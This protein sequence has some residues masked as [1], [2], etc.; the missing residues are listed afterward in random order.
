MDKF[1]IQPVG[2]LHCDITSKELAPKNYDISDQLG[3][4]EIY[5]KFH[6]ALEGI[7]K[8]SLIVVLFWLHMAERDI[9]KVHPRGDTTRPKRGVFST[10]SPVR[11]N[12][13]AIS[14]LKVES[15]NDNVLT[16]SGLDILDNTPVID[17]KSKV[18]SK[19]ADE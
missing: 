9:L 13:I 16:V 8:G 19:A 18:Y 10:R 11:P 3:T 2:I 14:E 17:I 4:I 5:P 6:A 12:P 7:K 1:I 15:I